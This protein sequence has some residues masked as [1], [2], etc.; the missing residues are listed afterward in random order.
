MAMNY[1][2]LFLIRFL[3]ISCDQISKE[4]V[5]NRIEQNEVINVVK[6]NFVLMNVENTGAA[7][8]LGANLSPFLKIL[9]RQIMPIILLA[10]LFIMILRKSKFSKLTQVGL[11]FAL[12]GGIGNVYDQILYESVT[13]F[14]YFELWVLKTGIFNM[15]DVS[16]TLG[17]LLILLDISIGRKQKL[18]LSH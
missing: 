2:I 18:A 8:S 16:V 7:L 3:N 11:A 15:A 12:G 10:F 5:R 17:T 1:L 4:M 6:D 13:D 14:M 9:V